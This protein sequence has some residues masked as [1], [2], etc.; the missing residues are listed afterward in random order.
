[1]DGKTEARLEEIVN[2]INSRSLPSKLWAWAKA[3]YFGGVLPH[4][5]QV[6]FAERINSTPRKLTLVNAVAFGII[7]ATAEYGSLAIAGEES[8]KF[9]PE[10]IAD[11]LDITY[12]KA[13]CVYI[14]YNLGQSFA[15]I[16]YTLKT[17][18]GA[19]SFSPAGLAMNATYKVYKTIKDKI[20]HR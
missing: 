11:I 15:R 3:Y 13:L 12:Q 8:K 7:G 5:D 9:I 19:M 6:K 18:R 16:S 17:A 2:G 10:Q 4:K 1:M 20:N 14:I